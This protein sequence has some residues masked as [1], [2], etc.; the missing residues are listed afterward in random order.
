M[1]KRNPVCDSER[2]THFKS[3]YIYVNNDFFQEMHTAPCFW[4][5]SNIFA[6]MFWVN[7]LVDPLKCINITIAL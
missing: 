1:S 7:I 3:K 2:K 6:V 5:C 4:C